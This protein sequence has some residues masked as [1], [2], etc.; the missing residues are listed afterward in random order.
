[1]REG[2]L[3][4]NCIVLRYLYYITDNMDQAERVIG[5][6]KNWIKEVV[7]GCNFCPFAAREL[8]MDSIHYQVEQSTKRNECLRAFVQEC[9]RLDKEEAIATTLLIFP[10]AFLRWVDY[11]DMVARAEKLLRKNGYEGIYQVASFHPLYQF[12]GTLADDAANYTNRSMYPMLHVLREA[13]VEKSLLNYPHPEGIPD[14]N[15][16]FARERGMAFMKALRDSCL[17]DLK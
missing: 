4:P 15:I 5:Q 10:N 14:R 17:Q 8:K 13:Q 6:T 7:V 3:F 9:V 16:L 11:L 12:A 1:M 2:K